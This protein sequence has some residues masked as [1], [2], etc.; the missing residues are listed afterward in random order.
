MM[1]FSS[2]F[3]SLCRCYGQLAVCHGVS[4]SS[5]GSTYTQLVGSEPGD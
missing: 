5:L 1:I 4:C 3:E 2:C